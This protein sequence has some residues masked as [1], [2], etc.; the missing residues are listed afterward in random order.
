MDMFQV[1]NRQFIAHCIQKLQQE[2]GNNTG[3]EKQ[4]AEYEYTSPNSTCKTDTATTI[5]EK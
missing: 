2:E 3:Y 4:N 5:Y 1:P